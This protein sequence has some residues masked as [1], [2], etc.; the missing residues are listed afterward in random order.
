MQCLELIVRSPALSV[1]ILPHASLSA[2]YAPGQTVF[3]S[4]ILRIVCT[5]ASVHFSSMNFIQRLYDASGS[6]RVTQLHG[7]DTYRHWEEHNAERTPTGPLPSSPFSAYIRIP[8]NFIISV[9]F[10]SI[11]WSYLEHIKVTGRTHGR[12][13]TVQDKWDQYTRR[14]VKEYQDFLLIVRLAHLPS[15]FCEC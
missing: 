9:A 1:P 4:W 14:I 8:L 12:N 2:N 3:I 7:Q 5:F 10:F 13:S 11:P 6:F 15:Y